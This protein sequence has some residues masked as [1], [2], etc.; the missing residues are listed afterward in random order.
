MSLINNNIILN[1]HRAM[2]MVRI[3]NFS[4]RSSIGP[5]CFDISVTSG[6]NH[7][8]YFCKTHSDLVNDKPQRATLPEPVM[9]DFLNDCIKLGVQ[10]VLFAGAG[11]PFLV[12]YLPEII[13]EY[14]RKIKIKVLTNGSVLHKIGSP[15]LIDSIYKLSISLNSI[16]RET[17]KLIHGYRDIRQF[18]RI[19]QG[20]DKILEIPRIRK[21][22]QINYVITAQNINEFDRVIEMSHSRDIFFAMRPLGISFDELECKKLQEDSIRLLHEKVEDL[23]KSTYL[24]QRAIETL[25]FVR[26]SLSVVTKIYQSKNELLPCYSGFYWGHI[27]G[28]GDYSLCC[29]GSKMLGNIREK[30]LYEIWKSK[31]TQSEIYS[32]ATMRETNTP[33][34]SY[35]FKCRDPYMYSA[36]F[37]KY[38][39]VI[40]FQL[41]MMRFWKR[42]KS[43]Q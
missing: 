16:S 36:L 21:K 40:P 24:N 23:L 28:N 8:C 38:F 27:Q 11:E 20:V 37:H 33:V 43:G 15:Q 17:H 4:P 9:R 34:C 29:H 30:S 26:G 42:R 12:K 3:I 5:L 32:A 2:K 1:A 25:M 39:S 19:M 10:E 18:D 41:A 31:E 35:C 22:L 6:C 7:K 14:G 13:I